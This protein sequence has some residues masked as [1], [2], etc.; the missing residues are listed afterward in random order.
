M[1]NKKAVSLK[2]CSNKEWKTI[3][4]KKQSF[5]CFHNSE[6]IELSHCGNYC[7]KKI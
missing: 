7:G 4:T 3:T 2:F 1:P 5:I 6:Q